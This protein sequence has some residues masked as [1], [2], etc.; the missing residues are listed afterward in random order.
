MRSIFA[1]DDYIQ[2]LTVR[3]KDPSRTGEVTK[4]LKKLPQ[5][6]SIRWKFLITRPLC[7]S[8]CNL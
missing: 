1:L 5:D 4:H 3:V 2:A 7:L 6:M 8:S